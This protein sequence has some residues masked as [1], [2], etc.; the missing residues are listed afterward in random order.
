MYFFKIFSI[1]LPIILC[2]TL[3]A[4]C[5]TKYKT[6]NLCLM[7]DQ[8]V[9]YLYDHKSEHNGPYKDLS[10]TK[11]MSINS[12]GASKKSLEFNRIARGVYKIQSND[13]IQKI[14]LEMLN[15]KD[16]VILSVTQSK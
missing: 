4:H 14:E 9:L 5:P 7:L 8:N 16:T 6:E 11:I 3:Y 1:F 2:E 15:G 13:K 10:S 12:I